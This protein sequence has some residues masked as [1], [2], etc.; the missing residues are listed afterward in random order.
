MTA[1]SRAELER[2]GAR[3]D[4]IVRGRESGRAA[5][6]AWVAV[7]PYA[8]LAPLAIAAAW[9]AHSLAERPYSSPGIVWAAAAPWAL[10]LGASAVA[11]GRARIRELRSRSGLV[12]IDR[13]LHSGDRL[14]TADELLEAGV[15]TPFEQAAVEDARAVLERATQHA[16]AAEPS[17]PFPR[18]ALWMP[19]AASVAAALAACLPAIVSLQIQMEDSKTVAALPAPGS[20]PAKSNTG[21]EPPTPPPPEPKP[22]RPQDLLAAKRP[23]ERRASD[24]GE[25]RAR[26]S[27]GKSGEGR[28]AD[29]SPSRQPSDSLGVPSSQAQ[30]STQAPPPK[31]NAKKPKP[32]ARKPETESTKRK[33]MQESGATAG[34]GVGSGSSKNPGATDWASKD[35]VTQ[36]EEPPLSED[37]DIDDEDS[38]QEARGGLQPSL[39]DR[40]PAVNRDLQIGFGNQPNPDANGRGGPSEQKKS[41]GVASLVLGVP[42]P[43]HVKGQPNPGRTKITQERVE[44]HAE[45]A[46][47]IVASERA[48]RTAPIGKMARF[49]A[50][51]WLHEVIRSFFL[52]ITDQTAQKP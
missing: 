14:L 26:E 43:D 8:W 33:P 35:Q 46:A 15:R 36:D 27:A 28:S 18:R 32:R 4:A 10:L 40:R 12:R 49:E 21:A 30:P 41:R 34:R 11:C 44:P 3:V 51:P 7:A 42:I 16:P 2:Q 38:E 19:A 45:E 17:A 23:E 50:E 47:S 39:R 13:E 6:S 20:R 25:A 1:V 9:G 37:V 29:A 5:A 48:A 52:K 22:R 24:P 31:P